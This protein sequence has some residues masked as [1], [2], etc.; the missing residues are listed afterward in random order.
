MS[1]ASN[2]A[3]NILLQSA[4]SD[5]IAETKL[6]ASRTPSQPENA[7]LLA[8]QD[9]DN[10]VKLMLR[11]VVKTRQS[12]GPVPL[13]TIDLVVEENGIAKSVGSFNL[14]EP[15]TGDKS[16]QLKLEKK[17][18]TYTAYYAINGGAFVKLG[19]ATALLKNI[20]A[21]IIACDGVI[22]Q[23]MKNVFYFDSDT[24]KPNTPLDVTFDYFHITNQ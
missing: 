2:N 20:K 16:L 23:S 13:A 17:G 1:E 24:T 11:A 7:G 5:W 19:V 15:I 4:N 6:T 21:G 18:N 9:D 12:R 8:Y 3:K 10:F 14:T 22:I